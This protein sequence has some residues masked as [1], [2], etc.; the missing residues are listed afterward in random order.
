MFSEKF[1]IF[2]YMTEKQAMINKV[3]GFEIQY[4]NA[5]IERFVSIQI[6]VQ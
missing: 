4:Q 5:E 2:F 1:L 6:F 3:R